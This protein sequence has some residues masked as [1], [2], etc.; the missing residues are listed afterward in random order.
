MKQPAGQGGDSG[1]VMAK[2]R[3]RLS[4]DMEGWLVDQDGWPVV[5]MLCRV[6]ARLSEPRRLVLSALDMMVL[7][8]LALKRRG[9]PA[10]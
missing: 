9:C 8:L 4:W 10:L 1:G 3:C 5:E 6:Q 7:M 2:A